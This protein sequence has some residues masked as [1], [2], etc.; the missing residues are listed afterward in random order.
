[1]F[2]NVFSNYQNEINKNA[3]ADMVNISQTIPGKNKVSFSLYAGLI[4]LRC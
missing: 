2:I 3:S 4:R 1:M